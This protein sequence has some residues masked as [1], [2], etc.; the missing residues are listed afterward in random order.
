[1]SVISIFLAVAVNVVVGSL[2][3]SPFIF[4]KQWTE[5]IGK[6]KSELGS[7]VRGMSIMVVL[8]VILSLVLSN[9]IRANHV[10]N[11]Q[12]VLMI[13]LFIWGG[14]VLPFTAT[15]VAFAGKPWKL[16]LINAGN[17][18]ISLFGMGL[19]FLFVPV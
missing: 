17:Q 18:L 11:I 19:V 16:F 7:P 14:F 5:L 13:T 2:W 9:V 6:N 4:G 12:D 1:M 10:T 15:D 8:A 3:Y